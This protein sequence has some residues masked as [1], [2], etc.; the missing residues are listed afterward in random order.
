[1]FVYRY[2]YDNDTEK[3]IYRDKYECQIDPEELDSFLIPKNSTEI[4]PNI[5]EGYLAYWEDNQWKY[6]EDYKNKIFYDKN[7]GGEETNI[8]YK[9]ISNYIDK[10]PL[11]KF[12]YFNDETSKWEPNIEYFKGYIK[13]ELILNIEKNKSKYATIELENDII[14]V[15]SCLDSLNSINSLIQ[16]IEA[17]GDL[18]KLIN[19]RL[20]NNE[21]MKLNINDL[22]ICSE[23]LMSIYQEELQ[24]KWDIK[25]TINKL[26]SFNDIEIYAENNNVD[27]YLKDENGNNIYP[28]NSINK[29]K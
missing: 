6:M 21:M 17:S 22:K 20:Y 23:K 18:E 19:F 12:S 25:D 15:N 9:E 13:N 2:K 3:Y 4:E 26:D 16:Y 7:N 24:T 29:T 8:K 10:K 14:E 1:M 27:I 11:Y 28:E 5:K